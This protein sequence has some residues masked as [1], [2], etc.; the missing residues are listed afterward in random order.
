MCGPEVC[1][2]YRFGIDLAVLIPNRVWV[3]RCSLELG[4]FSEEAILPNKSV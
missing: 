1:V 2:F 3:L 4:M